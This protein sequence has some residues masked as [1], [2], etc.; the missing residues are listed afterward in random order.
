MRIRLRLNRE[1]GIR[2][3]TYQACPAVI[4]EVWVRPAD[5]RVS[6]Y[7]HEVTYLTSSI[8]ICKLIIASAP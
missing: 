7:V 5:G 1:I 6:D 3:N 2:Q 4:I 8:K